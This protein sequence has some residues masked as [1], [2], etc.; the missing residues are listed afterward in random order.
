MSQQNVDRFRR[1]YERW[2][3]DRRLGPDLLAD[4]VEWVNPQDAVEPGVRKGRD[5]FNEAIQSV[6]AA[7]DEVRFE[8]ERIIDTDDDV[9]ALGHVR[10]HGRA[11]GIEVARDHGE[12]WTFRDGKVIRLRWFHSQS[13]T[14]AAA[15]L[16]D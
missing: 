9:V 13:E 14:L 11:T 16:G 12:I 3:E 15:G 6:F 8:T 7:W 10:G 4:D 2:Y 1:I 5:S